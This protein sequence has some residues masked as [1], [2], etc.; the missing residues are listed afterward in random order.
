MSLEILKKEILSHKNSIREREYLLFYQTQPGGY[1]EGDQF[2]GIR[3]PTRRELAKK[4]WQ[5]INLQETE[6]LLQSKYHEE[7]M[8]ALFILTHHFEK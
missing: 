5:N 7:R 2:L 1:G 4:H 3:V 6:L 8:I